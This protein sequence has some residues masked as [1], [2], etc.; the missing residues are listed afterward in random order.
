MIF[1]KNATAIPNLLDVPF[2]RYLD[3]CLFLLESTELLQRS[4]YG[5]HR[6]T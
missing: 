1:P 6:I 4:R 2:N 3:C 5:N